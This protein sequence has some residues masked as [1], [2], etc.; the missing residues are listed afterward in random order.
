MR[1]CVATWVYGLI[2]CGCLSVCQSVCLPARLPALTLTS[3]VCS[4]RGEGL[5]RHLKPLLDLRSGLTK[6]HQEVSHRVKKEAARTFLQDLKQTIHYSDV[7]CFAKQI[8]P[9]IYQEACDTLTSFGL[10]RFIKQIQAAS[11][12]TIARVEVDL[13]QQR[14]TEGLLDAPTIEDPELSDLPSSAALP[15][16]LAQFN[17][18]TSEATV[19]MVTIMPLVSRRG[20]LSAQHVVLWDRLPGEGGVNKRH[21]CTCGSGVRGGVPCR[22]FWAV[23]IN[24]REASFNFGLVNDLWFKEAQKLN[25]A[26]EVFNIDGQVSGSAGLGCVLC[27]AVLFVAVAVPL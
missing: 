9:D 8:L 22:H 2:V 11:L 12:Y 5:N 1:V 19:F 18:D 26:V 27:S 13:Q 7:G 23:A 4:Q 10:A 20:A 24:S 3:A 15:A 6:L 14:T 17:V 16:M 21:F 25:D